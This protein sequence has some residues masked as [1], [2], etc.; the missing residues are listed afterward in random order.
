M[1]ALDPVRSVEGDNPNPA[2]V[3]YENLRPAR[4]WTSF[5]PGHEL[6]IR[7]IRSTPPLAE[8]ACRAVRATL[9]CSRGTAPTS[10]GRRGR[11]D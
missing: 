6:K 3:L 2:L 7:K 8:V 10:P 1:K 4:I 11:S 5:L 9:S